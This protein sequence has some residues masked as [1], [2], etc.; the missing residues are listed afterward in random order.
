MTNFAPL[1]KNFRIDNLMGYIKPSGKISDDILKKYHSIY[2]LKN[3]LM[4]KHKI[5]S[6]PASI[7]DIPMLENA[8]HPCKTNIKI[9]RDFGKFNN[10]EALYV[11]FGILRI[12]K[13]GGTCGFNN[14]LLY[15]LVYSS[16]SIQ[17]DT[18]WT[19]LF[20]NFNAHDIGDYM[21]IDIQLL[22]T[23]EM[24]DVYL[25]LLFVSDG[26]KSVQIYQETMTC[27]LD[28]NNTKYYCIC[29]KFSN[30]DINESHAI[31]VNGYNSIEGYHI[32]HVIA[33]EDKE[34]IYADKDFCDVIISIASVYAEENNLNEN[35]FF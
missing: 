23:L 21:D 29:P 6:M 3:S 7:S 15:K 22:N 10:E 26:W 28:L 19:V 5:A 13:V 17:D 30:V 14:M 20:A 16:E 25:S 34:F 18:K 27:C 4:K 24:T 32:R 2:K 31:Y 1:V 33:W 8:S 35:E 9:I 11:P 12:T